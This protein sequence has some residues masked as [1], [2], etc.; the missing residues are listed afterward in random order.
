MTSSTATKDECRSHPLFLAAV[1]GFPM[2]D[3]EGS[4]RL[5]FAADLRAPDFF[6][7]A[8]R[9][10]NPIPADRG[11]LLPCQLRRALA[12]IV[13]VEENPTTPV[14]PGNGSRQRDVTAHSFGMSLNAT[15]AVVD[16]LTPEGFSA[17]MVL[18]LER[19]NRS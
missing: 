10:V 16:V 12:R 6:A 14:F 4:F 7:S 9:P 17:I 3:G 19:L 8:A 15:N 11:A 18:G 2:A 13:L 1:L 5:A